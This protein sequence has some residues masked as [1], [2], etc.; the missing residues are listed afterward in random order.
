MVIGASVLDSPERLEDFAKKYGLSYLQWRDPGAEALS[1]LTAQG[2]IP[3]T[4]VLDT[5]HRVVL[6]ELGYTEAKFE[7]VVRAVRATVAG[8]PFVARQQESTAVRPTSSD[9][10]GHRVRRLDTL[11]TEGSVGFFTS[12]A[13]DSLGHPTVACKDYSRD[14]LLVSTWTPVA[15]QAGKAW[16]NELVDAD[17]AG[18]SPSVGF[19][20]L[21]NLGV[22]YGAMSRASEVRYARRVDGQWSIEVVDDRGNPF[23]ATSLA[24]TAQ[25]DPLISYFAKDEQDLRLARRDHDGERWTVEIVDARGDV[26]SYTSL[27]LDRE[28][29]PLISYYDESHQDLKFARWT[30]TSWE[31]EVVDSEGQVG[32][33]CSLSLDAAGRPA[34]AYFDLT[35]E[36]L[37]LA[38]WKGEAWELEVVDDVGTVGQRCSLEFD[39]QGRPALSYFGNGA[40]QFAWWSGAAWEFLTVDDTGL[41]GNYTSLAL[42][43]LG[44]AFISYFNVSQADLQFAWVERLGAD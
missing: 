24:F 20:P 21:G 5:E 3:R 8:E 31:L 1:Q 43:A 42:D 23:K 15:T 19:D 10:L 34:I 11:A 28:G 37:K 39:A 18:W 35:N 7:E 29:R 4:V 30:G 17:H 16:K 36:A 26:G 22:S 14:G 13:L 2:V 44:S 6:R 9:A 38:R 41:T 25:G 12:V 27:C 40:L 33:H 32:L